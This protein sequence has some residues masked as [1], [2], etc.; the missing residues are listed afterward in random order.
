MENIYREVPITFS[1]TTDKCTL[2]GEQQGLP[3]CSLHPTTHS[4]KYGKK[5]LKHQLGQYTGL[6][7]QTRGSF[8][9]Y[10][11]QP[12]EEVSSEEEENISVQNQPWFTVIPLSGL[13]Q[14]DQVKVKLNPRTR[15]LVIKAYPRMSRSGSIR[16]SSSQKI[17]HIVVVP[18]NIRM[19]QLKVKFIQSTGNL[20]VVAPY[21]QQMNSQWQTQQQMQGTFEQTGFSQQGITIPIKCTTGTRNVSTS[22]NT[23]R[24]KSLFQGSSST[25]ESEST[26]SG[27]STSSTST[28]ESE[29]ECDTTNVQKKLTSRKY[30]NLQQLQSGSNV[31]TFK[32]EVQKFVRDLQ[33]IFYPNIVMCKIV[34]LTTSQTQC[35][36]VVDIKFVNWHPE[37]KVNV[38]LHT[39][40]PNVIVI[41]GQKINLETL[42]GTKSVMYVRR[43]ICVPQWLNVQQMVYRL[44]EEGV[45]RIKLPCLMNRT[46][47]STTSG[48]QSRSRTT[49]GTSYPDFRNLTLGCHG[50]PISQQQGHMGSR[51]SKKLLDQCVSMKHLN[52]FYSQC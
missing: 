11:M 25:S 23:F 16:G 4:Q 38:Q 33:K 2:H 35:Q 31:Q 50:N 34:P 15:V 8:K 22:R 29:S 27:S 40:Q 19:E 39:Q 14:P 48:R 10:Q 3:T 1:S 5:F 12:Q 18:K 51:I 46:S 49:S 17:H 9:K 6:S 24:N 42:S 26:T 32:S 43:E 37:N 45:L 20:V 41:E 7:G 30:R 28:S 44:K 13:V 47:T 36:L 21:K 52:P